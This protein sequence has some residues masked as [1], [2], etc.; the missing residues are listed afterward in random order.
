MCACM[1]AWW[2]EGGFYYFATVI[3]GAWGGSNDTEQFGSKVSKRRGGER[4]LARSYPQAASTEP[5]INCIDVVFFAS[6]STRQQQEIRSIYLLKP[7]QTTHNK[8][9]RRTN[10][11]RYKKKL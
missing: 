10:K 1:C 6:S 7:E 5:E 8:K 9:K 4:R 3:D 11:K 2:G